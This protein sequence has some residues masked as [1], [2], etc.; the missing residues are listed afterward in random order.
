MAVVGTDDQPSP[1]MQAGI[2]R[3][4]II[5]QWDGEPVE[6]PTKLSRL[7]AQTPVGKKTDVLI[8]RAGQELA[9]Q[10]TVGERPAR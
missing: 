8:F 9:M 10:V 5:L 7:V 6:S 3:G 1:A 2:R 4:D